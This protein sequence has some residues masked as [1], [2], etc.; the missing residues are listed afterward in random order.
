MIVIETFE[1]GAA[2]RYPPQLQPAQSGSIPH[3]RARRFPTAQCRRLRRWIL[4]RP[5]TELRQ[6]PCSQ[7]DLTLSISP[8][9]AR[10]SARNAHPARS[11]I[12]CPARPPRALTTS[13]APGSQIPIGASA[14]TLAHS[15]SRF[16]PLVVFGRR[17]S[18]A[19][20]QP[21]RK[22]SENLHKNCHGSCHQFGSAVVQVA[23]DKTRLLAHGARRSG[24]AARAGLGTARMEHAAGRRVEWIGKGEPKTGIGHAAPGLGRQ[25]GVEQ[26]PA[27]RDGGVMEHR[28]ARRASRRC[29]RDTSPRR[30][31]RCARP[32]RDCG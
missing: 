20:S 12:V 5:R 22:A 8:D 16:R 7:P 23:L 19:Y 26:R 27:C 24:T 11:A 2:P 10:Q 25:H 3:E 4:R 13:H 15:D 14:Q 17:H 1:R 29:G 21:E 18:G 32:P 6:R 9:A 31:S 30:G 28:V